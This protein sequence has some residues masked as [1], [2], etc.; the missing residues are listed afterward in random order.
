M[1]CPVI[2][3]TMLLYSC[4]ASSSGSSRDDIVPIDRLGLWFCLSDN[5]SITICLTV[6]K[7]SRYFL[8]AGQRSVITNRT[9]LQAL[10]L[11]DT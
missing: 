4:L 5:G 1:G 3:V 7:A 11:L 6:S 9:M 2:W 10:M 8:A